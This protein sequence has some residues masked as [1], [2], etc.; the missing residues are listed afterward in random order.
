MSTITVGQENS[1]PIELYYEDHGSGPA[2]VL[3]HGWPLSGRSWE[4]QTRALLETGHRVVTYD[5]RGFGQSSQPTVGY[6]YDT[7]A[8]DLDKLMTELDLGDV[9]LFGFSMGTGEVARY[10]GTYGTERV[11]RCG[12]LA[13]V[14][15]RLGKSAD[16]PAGLEQ[17]A[18][19]DIMA[20]IV[21]DRLAFLTSF[22][23]NFYNLDTFLGER[24]SEEVVHDSWNVAAAASPHGTVAC[25]P[26][27][28][29]DFSA[30]LP[31]VDVPALVV[32][33]TADRV[34]PIDA[35]GR[36]LHAALPD[37]HY[38]EI[39]GAPHGLLATHAAEVNREM[40]AFLGHE[41]RVP[42]GA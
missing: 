36:R 15:P 35:T 37:A 8:A 28:L 18:I 5:R 9:S 19:D 23:A 3:I 21:A 39:E 22:Y 4:R 41:S 34:L 20:A 25:V 1:A 7:F 2:V 26:A 11:A 12:F 16:N 42:A 13:S 38:V 24:I 40:L 31:K 14:P 10:V 6:D 32:H 33:G 29:T 27:W 30:D 17:A